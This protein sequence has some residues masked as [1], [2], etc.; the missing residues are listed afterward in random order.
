[1]AADLQK[2]FPGVSGFS[3]RNLWD[4]RSFFSA[5][6]DSGF[7]R[8][9]VA[10]LPAGRKADQ[11]EASLRERQGPDDNPSIGIILCA[12]K[13]NLEVE[14]ALKT[15]TNPIGVAEYQLVA[16]LPKQLKGML[17]TARQL[18]EALHL[19]PPKK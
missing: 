7:L 19:S 2:A 15:K 1:M 6:T 8:Q 13:D 9:V 5:N 11:I 12:E 4:M 16:R 14:F 17:P 10:E 18:S 3:A